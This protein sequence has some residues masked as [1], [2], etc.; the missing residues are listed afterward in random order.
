MAMR[1]IPQGCCPVQALYQPQGGILNS[2]EGIR[3]HVQAAQKHGAVLHTGEKV[4]RWHVLPSGKVEVS[5]D[6]GTYVAGRLVLSA[7]AWMPEVVPE[8]EVVHR[9]QVPR[10]PCQ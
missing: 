6:K 10:V 7:G 8:L 3:A 9:L 5:T 2:E 1:Y 4:Q